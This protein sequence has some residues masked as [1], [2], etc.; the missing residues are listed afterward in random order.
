M[1]DTAVQEA[2]ETTYP[3]GEAKGFAYSA[4]LD[5]IATKR[6]GLRVEK[7]EGVASTN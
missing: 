1:Y 2:F 3:A 7:K 4:P 6:A 5:P